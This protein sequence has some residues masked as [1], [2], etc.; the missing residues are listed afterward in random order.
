MY[1]HIKHKVSYYL[2]KC[3]VLCSV[4]DHYYMIHTHTATANRRNLSSNRIVDLMIN[5][6]V[7]EGPLYESVQLKFK[8]L[9]TDRTASS[10]S[11]HVVTQ[12]PSELG[13]HGNKTRVSAA[14]SLTVPGD[15]RAR[16]IDFPHQ[17]SGTQSEGE[18]GIVYNV[19]VHH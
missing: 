15:K 13:D 3:K 12:A 1:M 10:T 16:Y 5:N 2:K 7:Y 11:G 19:I 6:P 18:S 14:L 8:S 17:V 4:F 9:P